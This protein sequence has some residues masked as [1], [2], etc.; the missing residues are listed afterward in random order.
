MNN[1]IKTLTGDGDGLLS[2]SDFANF[3]ATIKDDGEVLQFKDLPFKLQLSFVWTVCH[4]IDKRQE[5]I[6]GLQGD[7]EYGYTLT[8]ETKEDIKG[9]CVDLAEFFGEDLTPPI[10]PGNVILSLFCSYHF[11]PTAL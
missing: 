2:S 4:D 6:A 9:L 3:V 10:T 1:C 7:A 11:K 5:C 8:G